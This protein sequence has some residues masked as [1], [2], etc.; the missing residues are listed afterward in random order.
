[1]IENVGSA[2][3]SVPFFKESVYKEKP[4]PSVSLSISGRTWLFRHKPLVMLIA[5]SSL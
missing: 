2:T 4:A 3:F 1:M 5:L